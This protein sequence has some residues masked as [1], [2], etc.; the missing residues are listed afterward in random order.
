MP[1]TA[2]TTGAAY[3]V[4]VPPT[5]PTTPTT[6]GPQDATTL[7]SA[8]GFQL[9]NGYKEE[10]LGNSPSPRLSIGIGVNWISPFGP[11]R[12]DIAKALLKQR[13]DDTKLFSFN[14]GTQF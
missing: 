3:Q 14:V 13:G 10:F 5:L 2:N 12:I 1:V 8:T 7:A 11:L 9:I 6:C 4:T